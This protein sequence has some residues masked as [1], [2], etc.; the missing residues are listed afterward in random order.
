MRIPLFLHAVIILKRQGAG[1]LFVYGM[2]GIAMIIGCFALPNR[3]HALNEARAQLDALRKEAVRVPTKST[4]IESANRLVP[5]RR[6][7]GARLDTEQHIETLM[8]I[9]KEKQLTIRKAEYKSE[10]NKQGN[11]YA[12]H[13]TIPFLA[14]YRQVR[15]FCDDV[16]RSI[17]FASIDAVQFSRTSVDVSSIEA[18]VVLTFYLADAKYTDGIP[19]TKKPLGAVPIGAVIH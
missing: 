9:A 17:P 7:L 15:A 10:F 3:K 11:Y 12:Y 18:K 14:G 1:R 8:A 13:V 5:L 2:L 16:L 19:A 4:V 6:T